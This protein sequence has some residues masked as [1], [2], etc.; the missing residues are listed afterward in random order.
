M[1]VRRAT[2]AWCARVY[3]HWL[4]THARDTT[5]LQRCHSRTMEGESNP[6]GNDRFETEIVIHILY[7]DVG[8]FF[9]T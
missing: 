5:W 6:F 4:C 3:I 2:R 7:V 9:A 8:N 1:R